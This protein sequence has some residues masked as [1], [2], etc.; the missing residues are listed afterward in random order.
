MVVVLVQRFDKNKNATSITYKSYGD[1]SDDKYPTFSVCL[2]GQDI[3]WTNE[4]YM[5][6]KLGMTSNHYVELL[7][8]TGWR[9]KYN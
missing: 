1:T 9:Y 3:Y 4:H 7:K 8:G 2:R 5:F 6:D